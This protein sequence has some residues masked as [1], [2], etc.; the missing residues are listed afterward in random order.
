MKSGLRDRNNSSPGSW[1]CWRWDG[2]NE[3]RSWRPEQSFSCCTRKCLNAERL[4]EVRSWRPEQSKR[5]RPHA[6]DYTGLNEVRSWRPE[7]S[8][9]GF[10]LL[11][12]DGSASMKSG[13]GDRNNYL[14]F[15]WRREVLIRRLNEVRSWR[16]EQWRFLPA[17]SFMIWRCLNEVRSWRPEQYNAG[18][19]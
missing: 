2:L 6:M 13:L 8:I 3:V 1:D 16:P 10:K 18:C 4:N 9:S 11:T 7:Q 12:Y 19:D 17:Q 15:E 14:L 5:F